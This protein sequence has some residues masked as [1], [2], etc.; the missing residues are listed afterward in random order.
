MH[1]LNNMHKHNQTKNAHSTNNE[2]AKAQATTNHNTKIITTIIIIIIIITRRS[3]RR[4]TRIMKILKLRIL[5]IRQCIITIIWKM[6]DHTK[7]NIKHSKQN[8]NTK[9]HRNNVNILK[10]IIVNKQMQRTIR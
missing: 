7:N 1:A 4:R 5:R 2:K 8:T 6:Q 10:M 3:R 9:T